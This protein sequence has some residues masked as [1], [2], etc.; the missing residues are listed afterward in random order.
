LLGTLALPSS[1]LTDPNFVVGVELA[2]AGDSG[3][4]SRADYTAYFDDLS[5]ATVPEPSATLLLASGIAALAC[6]AGISARPRR[7]DRPRS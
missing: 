1:V 4:F 5:I 3:G 2:A 7:F 6:A